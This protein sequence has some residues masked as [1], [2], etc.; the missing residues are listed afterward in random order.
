M[1]FYYHLKNLLCNSNSNSIKDNNK[2]NNK[3]NKE[4]NC[5]DYLFCILYRSLMYSMVGSRG[6][7]SVSFLYTHKKV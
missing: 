2:D 7:S 6:L 3:D 4:Y 1:L 5:N